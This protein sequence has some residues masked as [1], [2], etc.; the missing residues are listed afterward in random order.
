VIVCEP[1]DREPLD[2][3]PLDREPPDV[4]LSP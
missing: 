2:R 3:E 4:S 1:L